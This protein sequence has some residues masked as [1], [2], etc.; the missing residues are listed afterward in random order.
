MN[1]LPFCRL[2]NF[3]VGK[4]FI[5]FKT[6]GANRGQSTGDVSS[7]VSGA[8][9]CCSWFV[10]LISY[11]R[12]VVVLWIHVRLVEVLLVSDLVRE[13]KIKNWEGEI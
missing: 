12:G 10:L 7:V 3:L 2:L 4:R 8:I 5:E 11:W 9:V 6:L 13:R 1:V